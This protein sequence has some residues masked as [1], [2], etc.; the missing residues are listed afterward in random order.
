MKTSEAIW[1]A[2][3]WCPEC[4]GAGM[5]MEFVPTDCPNLDVHRALAALEG[6]EA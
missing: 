4:G 6:I 2:Q 1:T 5:V 3:G